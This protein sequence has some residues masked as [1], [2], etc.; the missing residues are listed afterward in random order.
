MTLEELKKAVAPILR[1]NSVEYAGVFGSVS[2]EEA[3]PDSDI[4]IV[5]KFSRPATFAAYLRLD[6][7]LRKTLGREID[8]ITEG[9]INK[10]L[11]PEIERDMKIIYGQR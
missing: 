8:L 5:V 1:K 10:F 11:R 3:R 6:E 2:R 7:E 9:S 4:D